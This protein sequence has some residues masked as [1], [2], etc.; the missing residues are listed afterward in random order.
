MPKK[1]HQP[2]APAPAY[3]WNSLA[4][5]AGGM[6]G[7]MFGGS[8]ASDPHPAMS[9]AH[10]NREASGGANIFSALANPFQSIGDLGHAVQQEG[11]GAL[12]DIMGA[13]D[14]QDAQRDLASRFNVGMGDGITPT[15]EGENDVTQEE[16]LAIAR[17]YSDIRR[18][19]TQIE[20]DFATPGADPKRTA[21]L[22][23]RTM[24]DIGDIMQTRVGRD[25]IGDLANGEFKTKIGEEATDNARGGGQNS[26]TED[27]YLYNYAM[28]QPG[29]NH[30]PGK[31]D[32]RSDVTLFHE[33]THAYHSM[34][35]DVALDYVSSQ[36]LT[37]PVAGDEGQKI[38]RNE[39]QAVGLGGFA[40]NKYTENAYRAARMGMTSGNRTLGQK[41]WMLGSRDRYTHD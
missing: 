33:L 40:A 15:G 3:D 36:G 28:Y 19:N 39:Y 20:L 13:L 38:Q 12:G 7:N 6:I 18:G 26:E 32:Y 41:D 35:N 31:G 17:Q 2:A 30:F 8:A 1:A 16:F 14:R 21:T 22:E 23:N 4:R 29:E 24:A 10:T 25:L 37:P 11:V 5:S 34:K 27:A 9:E